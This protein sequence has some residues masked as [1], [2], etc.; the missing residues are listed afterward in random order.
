MSSWLM[1]SQNPLKMTTQWRKPG[2]RH[3]VTEFETEGLF[4]GM[5]MVA[6]AL[7]RHFWAV[8]MCTL[9]RFFSPI[10]NTQKPILGSLFQNKVSW[11]DKLNFTMHFGG[12]PTLHL[13]RRRN[14]LWEQS[15]PLA[16]AKV[17]RIWANVQNFW[18]WES[19]EVFHSS[20]AGHSYQ[21]R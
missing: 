8:D 15:F 12:L 17:Y 18:R 14:T 16:K 2:F 20:R 5:H 3:W 13:C 10:L 19:T 1:L 11:L 6:S 21:G 4:S 9:L 7:S